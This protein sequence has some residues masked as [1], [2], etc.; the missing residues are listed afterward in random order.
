MT[1]HKRA[2]S[3]IR[4]IYIYKPFL[5]LDARWT[6]A[7][8]RAHL[9]NIHSFIS[10]FLISSF[11]FFFYFLLLFL[12]SPSTTVS[13]RLLLLHITNYILLDL[14]ESRATTGPAN[15]NERARDIHQK[16]RCAKY[17]YIYIYTYVL[18]KSCECFFV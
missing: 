11:P 1:Q 13:H 12:L 15:V 9:C 16:K 3:V 7:R 10:H 2:L 8:K 4:S 18:N 14:S 5:V 17:L 6:M